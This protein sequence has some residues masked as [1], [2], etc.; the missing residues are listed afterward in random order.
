VNNTAAINAK[1]AAACRTACKSEFSCVSA[2]WFI[3]GPTYFEKT[4]AQCWLSSW[5]TAPRID[6]CTL[7]FVSFFLN[8][9]GNPKHSETVEEDDIDVAAGLTA[10][11]S[12]GWPLETSRSARLHRERCRY[13]ITGAPQT[14]CLSG[15][16]KYTPCLVKTFAM[17]RIGQSGGENKIPMLTRD[18]A[19]AVFEGDAQGGLHFGSGRARLATALAGGSRLRHLA[20]K[21]RTGRLALRI[22]GPLS[23][24][25]WMR[26]TV[27]LA[28]ARWAYAAGMN[29]SVAYRSAH[30]NYD[31]MTSGR[32]GWYTSCIL[33]RTA[34]ASF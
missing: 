14:G 32:D 11:E 29:V 5:C 26:V 2:A 16:N 10:V 15:C 24:G 6:C 34:G 23:D 17:P 3:K 30:D 31:D 33:P 7:G 9:A 20:D 13:K 22:T 8:T 21:L 25:F 4:E 28:H 12:F 27:V 18:V 1:T 19:R